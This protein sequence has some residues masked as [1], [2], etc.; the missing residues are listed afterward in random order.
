MF[1]AF[2]RRGFNVPNAHQS[3]AAVLSR[4]GSEHNIT[5]IESV[6]LAGRH[7]DTQTNKALNRDDW[8]FSF[9]SYSRE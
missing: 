3:G 1:A 9:Y 4:H 5:V 2:V 6:P 7:G 8:G